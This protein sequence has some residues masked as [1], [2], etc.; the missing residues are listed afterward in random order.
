MRS[1]GWRRLVVG[2][3]LVRNIVAMRFSSAEFVEDRAHMLIPHLIFK[4]REDI[5]CLSELQNGLRN[6][7]CFPEIVTEVFQ[8]QGLD[9]V[10]RIIFY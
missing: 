8:K 9:E 6:V 5:S 7:F 1:F 10:W 2:E 4:C 3:S